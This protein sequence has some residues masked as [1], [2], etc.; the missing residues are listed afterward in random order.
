MAG[1]QKVNSISLTYLHLNIL[2]QGL[3]YNVS[4]SFAYHRIYIKN[5]QFSSFCSFQ[6]RRVHTDRHR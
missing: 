6:D 5:I 2:Y 1:I 4:K 3:I